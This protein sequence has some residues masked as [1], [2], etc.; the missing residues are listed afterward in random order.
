[1]TLGRRG[2]GGD[3]VGGEVR[4]DFLEEGT[5]VRG[6]KKEKQELAGQAGGGEEAGVQRPCQTG[7]S[8]GITE[9]REQ[10]APRVDGGKDGVGEAGWPAPAETCRLG[11]VGQEGATEQ[12]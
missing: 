4:E 11:S 8:G 6:G 7:R 12:F 5:C 2:S 9:H 10:G 3:S 1:M